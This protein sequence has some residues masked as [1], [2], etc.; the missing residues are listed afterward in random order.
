MFAG[1][2]AMISGFV[3]TLQIARKIKEN[4]A[5]YRSLIKYSFWSGIYI[6]IIAYL[7]FLFTGPGIIHFDSR[8]M[9]QSLFV[10]LIK[11]GHFILPSLDRISYNFV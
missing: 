9:D 6:L 7:Y 11:S 8:S 10:E 2:F 4:E 1:L 3:H 5:S